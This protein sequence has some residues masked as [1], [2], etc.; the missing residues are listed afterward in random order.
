[1]GNTSDLKHFQPESLSLYVRILYASPPHTEAPTPGI[2]L[3]HLQVCPY[4]APGRWSLGQ[5]Y[6]SLQPAGKGLMLSRCA[7]GPS[8]YSGH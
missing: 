8:G 2:L 4:P 3:E 7:E 1:M 5:V 6:V